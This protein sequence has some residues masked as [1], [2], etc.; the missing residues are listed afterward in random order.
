MRTLTAIGLL[1]LVVVSMLG[2]SGVHAESFLEGQRAHARYRVAEAER[3]TEVAETFRA[4]GA[5]WPPRGLLLRGF[6]REGEVELWARSR[7]DERLVRVE[8]FAVCMSSGG[9]GPKVRE[10]DLQVPEGLYQID[11]FN[12]ASRFHLALRVGYPNAVDRARAR[13]LGVP[14]GGDIM[15]HGGCATIGCL[16]LRDGPMERL[17]VAAVQARAG[18]GAAMPVHLHPCRY[19]TASCQ[20]ALAAEGPTW[21]AHW[22]ALEGVDA[23]F[24]RTATA[25]PGT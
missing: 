23:A 13:A 5:V 6:K 10:G 16:P 18:G 11:A 9:L 25:P 8:V 3:L 15:V 21:A 17:Y 2:G 1:L 7:A 22:A 19:E 12:P 20:S 4:A 14:P 24:R